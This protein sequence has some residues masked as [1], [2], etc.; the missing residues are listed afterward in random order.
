MH[1]WAWNYCSA[2]SG[3]L[4]KKE[5]HTECLAIDGRKQNRRNNQDS[6]PCT[7][8]SNCIVLP[9]R[10]VTSLFGFSFAMI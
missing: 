3:A 7:L 6:R 5:R 1:T 2:L 8:P 10:T 9:H 4:L